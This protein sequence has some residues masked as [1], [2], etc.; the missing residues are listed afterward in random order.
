MIVSTNPVIDN[1]VREIA[2]ETRR[3]RAAEERASR[4][5]AVLVY[6]ACTV[7]VALSLALWLINNIEGP[8]HEPAWFKL[9][10]MVCQWT[11][12]AGLGGGAAFGFFERYLR[13]RPRVWAAF[14]DLMVF[15]ILTGVALFLVLPA[16]RVL[17]TF[18]RWIS[19]APPVLAGSAVLVMG[20]V[21]FGIRYKWRALYGLGEVIVGVAVGTSKLTAVYPFPLHADW[22]AVDIALGVLCAGVYLVVRGLDNI[23]VGCT[24]EPRD[25]WAAFL[26]GKLARNSSATT[27]ESEV[28]LSNRISAEYPRQP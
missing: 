15:L 18:A 11:L 19:E 20:L 13:P 21:L 24:K 25:P 27:R 23:H 6:S 17:S 1:G 12:F 16:A 7:L 10:M 14:S 5:T 8:N 26:L 3:R 28:E 4:R 9:G 2:V 22:K